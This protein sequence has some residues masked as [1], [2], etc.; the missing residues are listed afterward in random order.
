VEVKLVVVVRSDLEMGKGKI[1]AQVAHAAVAAA[2][3][4]QRD[5]D[6]PA[7]V[8]QGQPKVVLKVTGEADL[9]AVCR[10][11]V[12]AGLPLHAVRDAGR[13]QLEPGT[14]TCAAIG[15]AAADRVDAVTGTLSLL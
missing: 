8:E 15:P 12:A 14:A 2:L 13:T 4:Q 7:W 6:F 1:A 9:L 5:R 10:D 11:A 3:A